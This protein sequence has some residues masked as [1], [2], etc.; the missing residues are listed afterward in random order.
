MFGHEDIPPAFEVV[1]ELCFE[2]KGKN[3]DE[4]DPKCVERVNEFLRKLRRKIEE[5]KIE[6]PNFMAS[7][8]TVDEFEHELLS[9]TLLICSQQLKWNAFA[10]GADARNTAYPKICQKLKELEFT[11][12]SYNRKLSVRVT[13]F[14]FPYELRHGK[15]PNRRIF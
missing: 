12:G 1:M 10:R 9:D 3:L 13:D 6:E 2:V 15:W 5:M 7:V 8:Q 4:R 14:H 11:E